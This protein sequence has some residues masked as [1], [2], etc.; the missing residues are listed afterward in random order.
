M[1]MTVQ[2]SS[3]RGA[4]DALDT[5][6]GDDE[7]DRPSLRR[8][9]VESKEEGERNPRI[10]ERSSPR[11]LRNLDACDTFPLCTPRPSESH[12][13]LFLILTSPL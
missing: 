13:T 6:E 9:K 10:E 2:Q 7:E 5:G 12:R 11:K 4:A 3:Y 1:L 8:K